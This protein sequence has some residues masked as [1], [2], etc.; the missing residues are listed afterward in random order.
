MRLNS[1]LRQATLTFAW[2][3]S[4]LSAAAQVDVTPITV[5]VAPAPEF[6]PVF[7]AR[8][9]GLFRQHGLDVTPQVT[10]QD[11]ATIQSIEAGSSQIGA[12]SVTSMLQANDS[13]LDLVVV[14]GGAIASKTDKNYGIVTKAGSG[15]AKAQDFVGKRVGVSGLDSFFHVLTRQWLTNNGVDYRKVSFVEASLPQ[16][17]DVMRAGNVAAVVTTEPFLSRT[18]DAGVGGKVFWIAADLPDGLPPFV[19]AARRDWVARNAQLAKGFKQAIADAIRFAKTNPAEAVA[20]YGRYIKL[21]PEALAK[22]TINEMNAD[23][24]PKQ[25]GQWEQMMRSQGMLRKPLDLE[26]LIAP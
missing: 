3:L 14:A 12:V 6:V 7:I 4:M 8:E 22:I 19:Y 25:L 16:L 18:I 15:L 5:N 10:Q 24:T 9:N 23:V 21:P 2:A 17:S 20:I 13:G 11:S 26:R 1:K